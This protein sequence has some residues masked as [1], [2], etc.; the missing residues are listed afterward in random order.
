M[1]AEVD[2]HPYPAEL[3]A[4]LCIPKP[5]VMLYVKRLETAGSL[6]REIDTSMRSAARP[7]GGDWT[8]QG[9]NSRHQFRALR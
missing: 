2:A 6:R 1:L 9:T 7:W 4:V 8:H 5:S 3:A